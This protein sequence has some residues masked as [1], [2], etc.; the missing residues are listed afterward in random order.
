MITIN[1]DAN[2]PQPS[3]LK[4]ELIQVQSENTAIDGSLQRNRIGQKYQ[5][6]L[7]YDILSTGQYQSLIAYFTT[8]SGVSYSNNQSDYAGGVFAFSGLPYFTEKEYV[9][10]SS[11]FRPLEVRIRQQ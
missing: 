3:I 8:G 9:P 1:G 6:T 10:G 2:T 5:A 11:L 7:T 4:E